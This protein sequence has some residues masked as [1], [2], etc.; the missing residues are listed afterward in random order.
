MITTGLIAVLRS[1]IFSSYESSTR[2]KRFK[3]SNR[4]MRSKKNEEVYTFNNFQKVQRSVRSMKSTIST[5]TIKVH[6]IWKIQAVRTSEHKTKIAVVGSGIVKAS[7]RHPVMKS[8]KCGI[9]KGERFSEEK[10]LPI[11]LPT[12]VPF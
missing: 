1:M 8:I 12:F 6:K 11:Y 3:R 10:W 4:S 7:W 5:I 9:S 2:F